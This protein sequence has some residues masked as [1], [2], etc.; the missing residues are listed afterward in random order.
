MFR[1]GALL[2]CAGGS[3]LAAWLGSPQVA[4]LGL[5]GLSGTAH[6]LMALS[7]LNQM[8]SLETRRA[9]GVAFGLVASKCIIEGL[10][11]EVLFAFMHMGLCGTPIAMAHLGGVAGGIAAHLLGEVIRP[12]HRNA[13][14]ARTP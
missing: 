6:G 7:G 14:K 4:A 5:C 8:R 11:G 2:F 9:G 12:G 13:P 1:A 3:L 10:T